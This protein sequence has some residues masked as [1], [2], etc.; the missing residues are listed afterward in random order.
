MLLKNKR[1]EVRGRYHSETKRDWL[2][3]I[4]GG[5]EPPRSEDGV[6][7]DPV[8]F[9]SEGWIK[10]L[11]LANENGPIISEEDRGVYPKYF[12]VWSFVWATRDEWEAIKASL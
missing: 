1:G 2:H 9:H 10:V 8:R 5:Q 12:G 3:R 6:C 11:V 7:Y 4:T